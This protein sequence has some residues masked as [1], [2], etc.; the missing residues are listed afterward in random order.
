MSLKSLVLIQQHEAAIDKALKQAESRDAITRKKHTPAALLDRRARKLFDYC[1]R[2]IRLQAGRS[3]FYLSDF[4]NQMCEILVDLYLTPEDIISEVT[5][6]FEALGWQAR[7]SYNY[8]E[9]TYDMLVLTPPTDWLDRI[10]APPA[11][12]PAPPRSGHRRKR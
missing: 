8:G 9:P 3:A 10:L 11:V 2:D 12:P 7:H 1:V 4:A 5:K 6:R